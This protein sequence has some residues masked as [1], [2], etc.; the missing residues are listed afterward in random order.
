M[1]FWS[2]EKHACILG[3]KE[4]KKERERLPKKP[5]MLPFYRKRKTE[6]RFLC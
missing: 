2:P 6:E 1:L 4:G 5:K 3:E